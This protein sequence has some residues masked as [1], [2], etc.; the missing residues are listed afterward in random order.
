MPEESIQRTL[1][2]EEKS[3]RIQVPQSALVG[4]ERSLVVLGEAGMG[5]SHLLEWLASHPGYS[6]CTARQLINSPSPKKFLGDAVIFVIDALDEVSSQKQGDAVDLV[7]QKL[8][9]LGYPRFVL[10]C[11]VSDWRSA[12]GLEAISEQY[13]EK[14]LEMHL[15]P[16]GDADAAAFLRSVF[17]DDSR[18]VIE[19]FN[20]RG[21]RGMLGNPQSLQMIAHVAK[22]GPLPETRSELFEKA[23][24]VLRSEHKQGKVDTQP[25]KEMAL[26]S[27]GAAFAGLILTGSEAI[28]RKAAANVAEG[29][30]EIAE[31]STLPNAEAIKNIL[32]TR[33][34]KANGADRFSYWHRRI[35]E[36]LG[37]RWLAKLANTKR[38]RRRLISMFQNQGLVP[39]NLRGIHAW[40]ARDPALAHE[41]I[42]ADPM[43]VIEY[44]DA[45]ALSVE[46]ARMLLGALEKLANSDPNFY[47]FGK[48]SLRGLMQPMLANDIRSLIISE[49]MPFALRLLLLD[50]L[51]GSDI[52][53]LLANELNSLLLNNSLFF[54]YRKSAG[55]ALAAAKIEKDWPLIVSRLLS[56]DDNLSIRLAIELAGEIGYEYFSN[57]LIG[58]LVV[59]Y[60]KGEKPTAGVLWWMRNTL[61]VSRIENVLDHITQQT[62]ESENLDLHTRRDE[63]SDFTYHLIFRHSQHYHLDSNKFWSWIKNYNSSMGYAGAFREK[64]TILIMNDHPLRQATQ[65]LALIENTREENIRVLAHRLSRCLP[66]FS[67]DTSDVAA[68]L[69]AL[70]PD[71]HSDQRWRDVIRLIHH[72]G[73]IGAETREL[74][75]RFAKH[76]P[77]LL[78]W[79]DMLAVPIIQDWEL[80][81]IESERERR[82]QRKLKRE[83]QLKDYLENIDNVRRGQY[84]CIIG[85]AK[86]YLN[87][88][89]NTKDN[90]PAHE[91]IADWLNQ[92]LSNA[93]HEGFEAYLKHSPPQ[94]NAE[95]IAEAWADGNIWE[96]AYI[97]VSAFAERSRK[98]IGFEDLTDERLMAV[99]FELRRSKIDHHA[100][101]DGL[102]KEIEEALQERNAWESTLRIYYEPQFRAQRESIDGLHV[103]LRDNNHTEVSIKLAA[104]WIEHFP[105]MHPNIEKELIN[106]LLYS[107]QHDQLRGIA[108]ERLKLIDENRR[109]TWIATSLLIDFEKTASHLKKLQTEPE[110]LWSLK[111]L[112]GGHFDNSKNLILTPIQL[113]WLISSFRSNW[114]FISNAEYET[115]GGEK[116]WDASEYITHLIKRLGNNYNDEAIAA[117]QRL[118]DQKTDG[119]TEIIRGVAA[120]Q[121]QARVEIDY[122]PPS[123]EILNAI[124][125]DTTPAS[126]IDLRTFILEELEI[127][128]AKIRGDDAESWRGLYDDK[129]VARKEEE[130]RDHL[131]GLLRQGSEGIALEPETHVANDKEVDITCSAG[132]HRIPIEIKGQ[133]HKDLWHGADTQLNKLYTGDWRAHGYGIYLVLWFGDKQPPNKK[134]KSPGRDFDI[135]QTPEELRQMLSSRS[136]AACNGRVVV[137]V[138]DVAR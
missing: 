101:F 9:E 129:I 127:V 76:D 87:L 70:D 36:F 11:R 75:K 137:F 61:P 10:S 133:W 20:V 95:E 73:E 41:V 121:A 51:K 39:A 115:Y 88:L 19:H 100:G 30:L 32:G 43:G 74:A 46:Q 103:L 2:H 81:N 107:N 77:E 47:N 138:L 83:K 28:V 55:S 24:D 16:F 119:Y 109:R 3:D 23:V 120:E 102:E 25:A 124:S 45:D 113:E 92:D 31:L 62:I 17:G 105:D 80:E 54:A 27:A 106:R 63:L 85:P 110:L 136:Q 94:P 34:F 65:R 79:I 57:N 12:T 135:P 84:R 130:C 123:L 33:L 131:L 59:A 71:D 125:R 15:E 99:L 29:E 49:E 122:I 52:V 50:A 72:E 13:D 48:P 126:A 58:D 60:T 53:P 64:L 98:G 108:T 18:A 78:V 67:P 111:Y 128:Q 117:I 114:P 14:P 42:A 96:S 112:T 5:K 132:S 4:H 134:L 40:L 22:L 35:G 90:K 69:N 8:G 21:L 6:R 104:D 116:P 44:G 118:R 91:R 68:L 1:W 7:L 86:A 37:A 97:L 56:Y 26:D 93:A 38:K 89:N 82:N 66:A